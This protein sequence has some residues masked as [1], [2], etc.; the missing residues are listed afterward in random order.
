MEVIKTATIDETGQYRYQ[1]GRCWVH[2][3]P[4]LLVVVMLNPSTA[5]ADQDDRT[6]K[7]CVEFAK[8]W[9]YGA[10]R[11]VNLFALRATD[12]RELKEHPDPVG[13]DNDR[14]LRRATTGEQVLCAWG[15]HGSLFGRALQVLEMM[16]TQSTSEFWR[17]A[18]TSKGMPKHPLY[19]RKD[20]V[21]EIWQIVDQ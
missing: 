20:T 3:H 17:F 9:G 7:R 11:V 21:P 8:S 10:I 13:P 14:Y 18:V 2:S 19:V 16:K 12:P 1:L 4:L 15:N 6:V 5:D